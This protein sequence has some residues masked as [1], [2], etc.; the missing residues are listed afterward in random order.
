[1]IELSS[2]KSEELIGFNWSISPLLLDS[3]CAQHPPYFMLEKTQLM[4]TKQPSPMVADGSRLSSRPNSRIGLPK[5]NSEFWPYLIACSTRRVSIR[6]PFSSDS[7]AHTKSIWMSSFIKVGRF[8]RRIAQ[9]SGSWQYGPLKKHV[10]VR[11][12]FRQI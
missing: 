1:M 4:S 3:V 8:M 2:V 7:I 9:V 10:F 11:E 12:A 6:D 5:G